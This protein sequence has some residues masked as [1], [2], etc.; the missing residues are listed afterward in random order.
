ML[1]PDRGF[2]N[3]VFKNDWLVA[4]VPDGFVLLDVV[5]VV[6]AVAVVRLL[7]GVL[8]V[9]VRLRRGVVVVVV[10]VVRR[11]F[12]DELRLPVTSVVIPFWPEGAHL[13][14]ILPPTVRGCV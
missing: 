2:R 1:V 13:G 6:V 11:T 14:T 7:L 3:H 5:E 8:V 9:V 12:T 10:V 4:A